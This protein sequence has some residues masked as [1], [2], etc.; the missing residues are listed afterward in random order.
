MA[1]GGIFGGHNKEECLN[2][3]GLTLK[4]V[5]LEREEGDRHRRLTSTFGRSENRRKKTENP[6]IFQH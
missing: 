3:W 4:R 1:V 5:R 6:P 2:D